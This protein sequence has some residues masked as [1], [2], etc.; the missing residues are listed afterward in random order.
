[1]NKY[2][3]WFLVGAGA[4]VAYKIYKGEGM[5]VVNAVVSIPAKIF[6]WFRVGG[7]DV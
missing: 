5:S 2:L 1:M 4:V 3:V 7:K 6:S